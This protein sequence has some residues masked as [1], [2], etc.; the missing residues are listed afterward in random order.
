MARR[1]SSSRR[2]YSRRSKSKT[3]TSTTSQTS[4]QPSSS[5]SRSYRA[6]YSRRRVVDTDYWTQR[7]MDE[8]IERL[9]L[10]FL[11]LSRDEYQIIL[12]RIVDLLRGE[13]STIN[14]DTIVR[15]FQR[16]LLHV[17]SII[18]STILELK[19]NLSDEQLEFVINNI[20][21]AVLVY[22]PRLYREAMNRGNTDLVERLRITWRSAWVSR[23]YPVLP[24]KCPRC[25]FDSLMPDLTCLVCGSAISEKELKESVNF[26]E[27]L[28][29]FAQYA[30]IDE[31]KKAVEYGY[32]YLTSYGIKA[33]GSRRELLD[34]EVVLSYEEKELLKKYLGDKLQG[35][36]HGQD[37]K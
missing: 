14:M 2:S 12:S 17:Y 3:S 25:G 28:K 27:L 34:I 29:E 13:A 9:G 19:D 4:Q 33:P 32:V 1:R 15:R 18:A 26:R 20:G 10:E 37:H 6:S 24:V 31:L 35:G 23:R 11:G 7:H 5:S 30:S 16:N 21:D 22:A 36:N 8:L